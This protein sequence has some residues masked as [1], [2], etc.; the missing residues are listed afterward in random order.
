MPWTLTL[1]GD[2]PSWYTDTTKDA[3][4]AAFD[5]WKGFA[6]TF[7]LDG[8][9]DYFDTLPA[10]PIDPTDADIA[11]LKQWAAY[12]A[13]PA[14][15]D[16]KGADG[17]YPWVGDTIWNDAAGYLNDT[18]GEVYGQC[19]GPTVVRGIEAATGETLDSATEDYA[20]SSVGER[21]FLGSFFTNTAKWSASGTS[22]YPYQ[23]IADLWTRGFIPSF[24]GT[25]WRLSS[26]REG[27]IVYAA[28][29][30]ELAALTVPDA[31]TSASSAS[32]GRPG[33][34]LPAVIGGGVVV[35]AVLVTVVVALRRKKAASV[36]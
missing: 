10:D 24:D 17:E 21:E 22:E 18:F 1:D 30:D 35:L 7:D 9:L 28:T 32:T 12:K 23:P 33:W 27:T 13:D 8:F 2:A 29:P 20:G 3:I 16:A 14:N 15:E 6:Y 19:P 25:T 11:L 5:E 31:A 34:V 26:G 36:R 4:M